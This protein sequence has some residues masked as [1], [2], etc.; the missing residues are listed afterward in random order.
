VAA[1]GAA[2]GGPSR[3]SL[4][5]VRAR[6]RPGRSPR[7]RAVSGLDEPHQ[8]PRLA[9]RVLVSSGSA[10]G[11]NEYLDNGRES[12]MGGDERGQDAGPPVHAVRV[13]DVLQV[14]G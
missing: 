1:T 7:G 4:V 14:D 10:G 12:R 3:D 9:W 8:G 5:T 6:S 2:V 11:I 13:R